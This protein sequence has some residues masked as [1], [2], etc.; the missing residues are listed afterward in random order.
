MRLVVERY[1]KDAE[2]VEPDTDTIFKHIAW[3]VSERIHNRGNE[4][5]LRPKNGIV[6]IYGPS[7]YCA[8]CLNVVQMVKR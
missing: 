4:P 1:I 8:V 7:V 3:L 6:K 2:S 5:L